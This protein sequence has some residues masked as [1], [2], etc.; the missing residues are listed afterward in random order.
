[1]PDTPSLPATHF[2]VL[3]NRRFPHAQ[4]AVVRADEHAVVGGDH[5]LRREGQEVHRMPARY[6]VDVV[7]CA[8]RRGA[9]D[10]ARAHRETLG[11]AGAG[12][13]HLAESGA[14]PRPASGATPGPS[15]AVAESGRVVSGRSTKEG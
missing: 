7:A 15:A 10:R 4:A 12:T 3:L 13:F 2:A 9:V 8:T 14:A 1:M 11:G 5:V 6:V